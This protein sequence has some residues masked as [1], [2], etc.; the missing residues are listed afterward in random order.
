[1]VCLIG[2]IAVQT[3][4]ALAGLEIRSCMLVCCSLSCPLT[5]ASEKLSYIVL[6]ERCFL[7]IEQFQS[8]QFQQFPVIPQ[9]CQAEQF[10][11]CFP[12]YAR[13]YMPGYQR[14]HLRQ[15]A[16]VQAI[17]DNIKRYMKSPVLHDA[18]PAQYKPLL[19]A[20]PAPTNSVRLPNPRI[21]PFTLRAALSWKFSHCVRDH[22]LFL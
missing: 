1:M 20:F 4:R 11:R 14:C 6:F 2:H 16:Q 8:H 9:L 15:K 5:S 7:D 22:V 18:F 19:T 13:T 10:R 12:Q 3:Y 21:Q 17:E